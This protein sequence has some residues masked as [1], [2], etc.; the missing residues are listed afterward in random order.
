MAGKLVEQLGMRLTACR[1]V[2]V[3]A[4]GRGWRK[5]LEEELFDLL[6][7]SAKPADAFTA[8][9]RA[10]ARWLGDFSAIVAD[11]L[12]LLMDQGRGWPDMAGHGYAAGAALDDV[13]ALAAKHEARHAATIDE[14][15]GLFS[16]CESLAQGPVERAAEHA[17]IA[18]AKFLA[19]IDDLG[20]GKLAFTDSL[21]EP[22]Q[23][24]LAGGGTMK[25]FD[26]RRG[27]P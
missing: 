24:G 12:D 23:S 22:Q 17:S 6:G 5:F 7:S 11:Q 8:A 10:V 27:G 16:G 3:H 14:Q 4:Y 13:S 19:H 2:L 9:D 20:S 1:R 18:F 15:H 26:G 21:V 25:G